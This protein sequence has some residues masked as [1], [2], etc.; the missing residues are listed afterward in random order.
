MHLEH[1]AGRSGVNLYH[2]KLFVKTFGS[3]SMGSDLKLV[4]EK[5]LNNFKRSKF[6]TT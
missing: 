5:Q 1:K 6:R 3:Q 2:N 4:T